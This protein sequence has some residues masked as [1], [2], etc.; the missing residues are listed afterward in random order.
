MYT[1]FLEIGG[2]VIDHKKKKKKKMV[3]N[4]KL[5][6]KDILYINLGWRLQRAKKREYDTSA[7]SVSLGSSPQ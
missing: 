7:L 6:D 3:G 2:H 4:E 5:N 1:P